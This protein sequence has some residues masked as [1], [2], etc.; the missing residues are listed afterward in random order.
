MSRTLSHEE[1]LLFV[2]EKKIVLLLLT[3]DEQ[4]GIALG[5]RIDHVEVDTRNFA[6]MKTEIHTVKGRSV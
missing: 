4:L 3:L 6:N 2:V 1:A 5:K